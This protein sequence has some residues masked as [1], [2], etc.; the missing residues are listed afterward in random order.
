MTGWK[1]LAEK[2]ANTYNS[3]NLEDKKN[4][5]IYCQHNYGDAGAIHF[6]GHFHNLPQPVTFHENYVSWAPDSIPIV[7]LICVYYNDDDLKPL[8]YK[9]KETASIDNQWFRENGLKV[10]LCTEPKTDVQKVYQ[11][12]AKIEKSKF[13]K[14][15]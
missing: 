10:F 7:P 13:Q 12:L 14:I 4:C 6:Y 2:V 1:E 5:T 8:F 9:I 15:K 3:L 11:E